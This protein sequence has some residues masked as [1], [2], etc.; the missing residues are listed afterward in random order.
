MGISYRFSVLY[1]IR[2]RAALGTLNRT[3]NIGAGGYWE[4][5]V[6]FLTATFFR[7]VK[8]KEILNANRD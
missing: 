4:K 7:K 5:I 6:K 3:C 8:K 2:L 1:S